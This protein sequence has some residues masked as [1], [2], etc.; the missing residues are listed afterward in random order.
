MLKYIKIANV[1]KG[2]KMQNKQWKISINETSESSTNQNDMELIRQ[3][4]ALVIDSYKETL[5]ED[6]DTFIKNMKRNNLGGDDLNRY[7][8]WE[9]PQGVGLFGFWKMFEITKE[10][11]YL[12]LITRYYEEQLKIG[13]PAKNINTTAPLLTLS[14]LYEY[15]KKDKYKDIC[16]EWAEWLMEYL[17]KT[18][19][20]GFQHI[21]SDSINKNELWADTLFMT[22]L[23][24]AKMGI[25]LNNNR[26]IEEAKY[27]FLLHIKYLADRKSGLWYHGWTF[28]GNHN[29]AKALWG[30]GNCWVTAAIPEFLSIV[31]CEP[32]IRK[33]LIEVLHCQIDA[34]VKY[35]NP[36]GMWHTLLDDSSSYLEASATC[37]IAYGIMKAVNMNIVDTAYKECAYKAINPILECI[38]E[39]GHVGQVSYGTYMGRESK[40]YYKEVEIRTMPY[41]QALAILFM[42]EVLY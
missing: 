8:H 11:K 37:G 41:G 40:Q 9:W 35:Q 28:E 15:S 6:D 3:K 38:D 36:T 30:R 24:L 27:Q 23:F 14:Y 19:E 21:T 12:E 34:L 31:E 26:W 2:R 17:P 7:R 10:S 16:V 29:F 1:W 39:K 25:V 5:Y 33:Y 18:K 32:S 22:V 4:L 13:L 20:G 42:L